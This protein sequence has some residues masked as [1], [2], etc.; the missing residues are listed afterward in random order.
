MTSGL[1]FLIAARQCEI[2]EL[3]Q[4]ARTSALVDA[5][6]RFAHALQRERGA[7]N[8]LLA[9]RGTRFADV[10]EALVHDSLQHEQQVRAAFDA[11]DLSPMRNGTRLF[12]R[13]AFVLHGLD[14]LP[15]LR[16]RIGAL[17]LGPQEATAAFVRLIGGLLAVVF[18]AA[19]GA[20]DPQISRALVALFNL[21]QGKEFAGQERAHGSACF[22][23]GHADAA[24]QQQW[25][26]LIELQER[27][28]QVAADFWSPAIQSAWLALAQASTM[29]ELERLRRIGCALRAGASLDPELA[30]RWY[31]TCTHRIDG[32]RTVEEA[33]AAWLHQLCESRI[34]DAQAELRDQQALQARLE[35]GPAVPAATPATAEATAY[36][37]Q[38][39]R[40]VLALLQ[41]QTQRL[42]AMG[43]ELETARAALTER[44]EIERA[45]G[46]L[47]AHRRLTED[48]AYKM[49][50]QTAMQQNRRVA[51][52]ARAVLAMA[53]YLPAPPTA[54]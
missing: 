32:M 8:L 34:A 16:A 30:Q 41:E 20:T 35:A 3:E 23:A 25:L 11:L 18:E 24:R 44:K 46:L 54:G 47:M 15:G 2:D 51:D 40:S 45:K 29:A 27:S 53:D 36:G 31:D 37:P 22:A 10:L 14:T 1:S 9:S 33:L 4:L 42:Q 43:D 26:H 7:S 38:V 6:S 50:R 5:V 48:E 21:M 13:I 39:E 12:S 52:V 28:F 49:L 19:D 17:A